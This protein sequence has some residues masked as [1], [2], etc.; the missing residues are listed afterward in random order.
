MD[1]RNTKRLH[2]DIEKEMDRYDKL[3]PIFRI[4]NDINKS[5]KLS[6]KM[7]D[8]IAAPAGSRL[9]GLMSKPTWEDEAALILIQL[10]IENTFSQHGSK[11]VMH[12]TASK[13]QV[14]NGMR[15]SARNNDKISPNLMSELQLD[16]Q[17]FEE[18]KET[19][20]RYSF[21]NL[22]TENENA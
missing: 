8:P 1:Y 20:F 7:H 17:S 18:L 13:E 9:K 4:K 3:N 11:K 2:P 6:D 10:E 22:S 14:S 5:R 12:P 15:F 19:K 21:E 16:A